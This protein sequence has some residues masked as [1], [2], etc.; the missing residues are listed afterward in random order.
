MG[1]KKSDR[2]GGGGGEK[3]ESVFQLFIGAYWTLRDLEKGIRNP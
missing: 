3:K 2:E 1:R